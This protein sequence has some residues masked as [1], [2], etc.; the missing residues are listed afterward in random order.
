MHGDFWGVVAYVKSFLVQESFR[1]PVTR[2]A[3]PGCRGRK[4]TLGGR[5]STDKLWM[6]KNGM[7][8]LLEKLWKGHERTVAPLKTNMTLENYHFSIGIWNT[9]SNGWFAIVILV[10]W[11]YISSLWVTPAVGYSHTSEETISRPKRGISHFECGGCI[12]NWR[13]KWPEH[14]GWWSII[15][16]TIHGTGIF[17]NIHLVVFHG[18]CR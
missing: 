2:Q 9:S 16:H 6:S 4:S 15:T 5:G 10:F 1:M 17:T 3:P 14:V 11:R 13:Q 12:R 7:S 18:K 8:M